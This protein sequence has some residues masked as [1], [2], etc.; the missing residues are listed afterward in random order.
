MAGE[1]LFRHTYTSHKYCDMCHR[2]FKQMYEN[3]KIGDFSY[4]MHSPQEIY[5][6]QENYKQK[7]EQGIE[8]NPSLV[9]GLDNSPES[10]II[11]TEDGIDKE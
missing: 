3:V 5:A 4:K 10:D 6:A 7:K 2:A 8:W 11:D 1:A 9:E